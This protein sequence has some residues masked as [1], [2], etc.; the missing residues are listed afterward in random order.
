MSIVGY[1]E[2][3]EIQVLQELLQI[4]TLMVVFWISQDVYI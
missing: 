1:H 4:L 2:T 3:S